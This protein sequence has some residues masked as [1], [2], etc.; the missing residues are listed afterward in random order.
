MHPLTYSIFNCSNTEKEMEE[1]KMEIR[2]RND[3][4]NS[5]QNHNDSLRDEARL[6]E[7]R[8]VRVENL[9]DLWLFN[10]LCPSY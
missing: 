1:L 3:L 6:Y 5:L 10:L 8:S 4:I 2:E 9:L 7:A